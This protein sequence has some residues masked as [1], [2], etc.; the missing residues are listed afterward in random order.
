MSM[1]IGYLLVWRNKKMS[2]I[3]CDNTIY[4][5]KKIV[6]LMNNKF[7]EQQKAID[8]LNRRLQ[9]LEETHKIKVDTERNWNNLYSN[10]MEDGPNN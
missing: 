8:D 9:K 10:F 2:K 7:M 1:V 3:D 6:D 4:V 5:G